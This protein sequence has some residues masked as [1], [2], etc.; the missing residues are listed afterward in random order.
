MQTPLVSVIVP[1]K[2]SEKTLEACLLSLRKQSHPNV[3]IIVVD[4]Y[5]TDKTQDISRKNVDVL[6]L[7]GPERSTQRNFGVSQSNGEYILIIDSDMEVSEH[8]VSSCLTKI[9]SDPAIKGVIIPEESFGEGFWAA[10]KQLERSF[11][12]G[13]SAVEGA[14]F[15]C[16]DTYN[17]VGGFNERLVSG[18]DWDLSDRVEE[19][20]KIDRI[21]EFI[22]HNEGHINLSHTLKKKY[23]Y[24]QKASNFLRETSG[25][26]GSMK[27]KMGVIGRYFLFFR[28]PIKLFRNPILGVGMLFMKTCEFG[29]GAMGILTA[30][31]QLEPQKNNE[32]SNKPAR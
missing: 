32:L 31:E 26:A 19:V 8:V 29:A 16:K 10:C 9:H 13:A 21:S 28:H 17:Q 25:N 22:Y 14:R 15:F 27:R 7:K 20:G 11:Y 1:T 24:A 30:G 6:Y 4:N 18:E 12:V 23:Y 5:S 3:E 2:D